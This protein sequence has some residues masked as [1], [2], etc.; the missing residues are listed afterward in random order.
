MILGCLT[1]ER[2]YAILIAD[3]TWPDIT[4]RKRA[5][6]V[7]L[8]TCVIAPYQ[9]PINN[10]NPNIIVVDSDQYCKEEFLP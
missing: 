3:D 9:K 4:T 2:G 6:T 5:I 8:A 7:S 1:K 10:R